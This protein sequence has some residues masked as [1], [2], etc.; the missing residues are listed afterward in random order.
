MVW[1]WVT[2]GGGH[3]LARKR[4]L[5]MTPAHL[6]RTADL[7]IFSGQTDFENT[8]RREAGQTMVSRCQAGEK[9]TCPTLVNKL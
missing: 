4:P 3:Q 1:H 5:K 6:V 2:R 8:P 9:E 7:K